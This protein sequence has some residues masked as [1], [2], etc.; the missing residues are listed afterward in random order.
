M[1]ARDEIKEYLRN[2]G[3]WCWCSDDDHGYPRVNV[4]HRARQLYGDIKILE[5]SDQLLLAEA[6]AMDRALDAY[7]DINAESVTVISLRFYQRKSVRACGYILNLHYSA[8]QRRT[9]KGINWLQRN[10]NSFLYRG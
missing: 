8:V 10:F 7:K 5:S 2:W 4:L 1:L 9:D 3:A 6:I